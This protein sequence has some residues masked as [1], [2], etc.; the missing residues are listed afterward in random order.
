MMHI[1]ITTAEGAEL[2]D[3]IAYMAD[4]L[5][6]VDHDEPDDLARLARLESIRAKVQRRTSQEAADIIARMPPVDLF[7]YLADFADEPDTR[8]P[9]RMRCAVMA[10]AEEV[11][12]AVFL[13]R[14]ASWTEESDS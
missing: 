2:L 12:P 7:D 4:D 11:G 5:G 3:L 10:D 8:D 6:N 13:Q 14:V 1:E 9:S